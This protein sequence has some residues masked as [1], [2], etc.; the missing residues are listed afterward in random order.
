MTEGSDL[1]RVDLHAHT[2]HSYDGW[3]SPE[4]LVDRARA[5]GL[6]RIAVTDHGTITGALR[7]RTLDPEL[8]IVG[9]EIRCEDE[10][11]L[12]GLFLS[13][14]V[15]GG[16]STAETAARIRRQ[17]GVVYAPHPFAYR[18]RRREHAR[19]AFAVADVIEAFNS[20]AFYGGW[21]RRAAELARRRGLPLAAG[22]DAHFPWEIGRGLLELPRFVTAAD[23]LQALQKSRPVA[24]RRGSLLVHGGS[25]GLAFA[26]KHLPHLP[27]FSKT[28]APG[29]KAVEPPAER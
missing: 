28:E 15:P 21:N 8:V 29:P 11:E 16:L 25:I 24:K 10:T 23:F 22:S 1:V 5:L 2:R 20:R 18:R 9:E 27:N 12:I 3:T 19:R 4:R 17:G 14:H 26:R 7:A 13:E 6:Y